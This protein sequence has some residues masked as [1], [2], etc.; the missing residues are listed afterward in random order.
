MDGP[1][2]FASRPFS[3]R[4]F[5][6]SAAVGGA[7]LV[8]GGLRPVGAALKSRASDRPWFE[9]HRPELQ[10]LMASGELS[11]RELTATT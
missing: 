3:R 2:A 4:T 10:E 1:R 7:S 9:A 6:A 8:A 5:L 11:S